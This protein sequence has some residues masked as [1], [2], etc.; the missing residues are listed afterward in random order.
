LKGSPIG[1]VITD[2]ID[3]VMASVQEQ[4]D[5]AGLWIEDQVDN[6]VDKITDGFEEMIKKASGGRIQTTREHAELADA[7]KANKTDIEAYKNLL[8]ERVAHDKMTPR[9]AE[10]ELMRYKASLNLA[11]GN[12]DPEEW[13]MR[14]AFGMMGVREAKEDIA[15]RTNKQTD[16]VRNESLDIVEKGL[17][18]ENLAYPVEDAIKE[19]M[20]KIKES[21][22]LKN[23]GKTFWD[24]PLGFGIPGEDVL[25]KDAQAKVDNLQKFLN[26]F[27]KAIE[28][29]ST[30]S[31]VEGAAA[32]LQKAK[33]Y[34]DSFAASADAIGL[35]ENAKAQTQAHMERIIASLTKK[36]DKGIMQAAWE[37]MKGSLTS[38]KEKEI[39]ERMGQAESDAARTQAMLNMASG[40]SGVGGGAVFNINTQLTGDPA[41]YQ[42]MQDSQG[43][44]VDVLNKNCRINGVNKPASS[45]VPA[46][47]AGRGGIATQPDRFGTTY[48]TPRR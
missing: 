36:E 4:I 24:D 44:I 32:A 34:R 39:A 14:K 22:T 37:R 33:D 42:Q 19:Q 27:N 26:G 12:V 30:S 2:Q 28:E 3:S 10:R 8:T 5:R 46:G 38:A 20:G 48:P 31:K 1:K 25:S 16:L 45:S 29:I 13:A 15:S 17:G 21:G 6:I 40:L 18:K 9:Q 7:N 35:D 43:A 11:N 41:R 47:G 23:G